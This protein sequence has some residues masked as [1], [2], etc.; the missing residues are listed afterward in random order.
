MNNT[1]QEVQQAAL[2]LKGLQ[3]ENRLYKAGKPKELTTLAY[4]LIGMLAGNFACYGSVGNE[5]SRSEIEEFIAEAVE[6]AGTFEDKSTPLSS[7]TLSMLE[8]IFV[9]AMTANPSIPKI[10]ITE[11]TLRALHTLGVKLINVPTMAAHHLTEAKIG[12][13]TLQCKSSKPLKF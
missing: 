9:D 7:I 6:F 1:I 4:A 3:A 8:E 13:V 2:K 5:S 12:G 10:R 11:P